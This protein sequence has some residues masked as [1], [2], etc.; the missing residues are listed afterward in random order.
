MARSPKSRR[1]GSP[2]TSRSKWLHS[3]H[4]RCSPVLFMG[5]GCPHTAEAQRKSCCTMSN[6]RA[7]AP[8][9]VRNIIHGQNT[10]YHPSHARGLRHHPRDF[11]CHARA[12]PATGALCRARTALPLSAAQPHPRN[13]HL[14]H[15]RYAAHA[16]VALRLLCSANGR[17]PAPRHRGGTARL[18]PQLRRLLRRQCR[19]VSSRRHASSA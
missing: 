12:F 11:L 1:S 2:R 7:A 18:R 19:A 14:D 4:A 16:A 10:G 15:A 9:S 17:H 6:H 3:C 13:L 8:F 5:G